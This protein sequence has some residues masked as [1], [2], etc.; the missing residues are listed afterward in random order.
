MVSCHYFKI[1]VKAAKLNFKDCLLEPVVFIIDTKL[2]FVMKFYKVTK[3]QV[4]KRQVTK[5]QVTK[6]HVTKGHVT[7]GHVTKDK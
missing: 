4:T 2:K 6:G 5:G 3:G 1:V 7:K